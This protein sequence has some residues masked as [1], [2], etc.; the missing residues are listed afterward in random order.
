MSRY[1][2]ESTNYVEITVGWDKPLGT[3]FAQI[4]ES[5]DSDEP[6]VWVGDELKDVTSVH[7]LTEAIAPYCNIP[8]DI[9]DLLTTDQI[10]EPFTAR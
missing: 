5:E 7:Q 2:I 8:Q 4:W 10:N 1:Q 6:I 3:Y 9:I